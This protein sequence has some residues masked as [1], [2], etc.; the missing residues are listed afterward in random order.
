MTSELDI[1]FYSAL[2]VFEEESDMIQNEF[3][4]NIYKQKYVGSL[5][6]EETGGLS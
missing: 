3:Q 4:E 5:N 1:L 2:T 6:E